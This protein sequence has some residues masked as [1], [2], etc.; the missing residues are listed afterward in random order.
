MANENILKPDWNGEVIL[1]ITSGGTDI[2]CLAYL[3]SIEV[4]E[5]FN[6]IA[7]ATISFF[8]DGADD[9][10][11]TDADTFEPGKEIEIFVGYGEAEERLFS[12]V[13]VRQKVKISKGFPKLIV[14]SKHAAFRMTLSRHTMR[15][16]DQ[17]DSEVVGD[18]IAKYGIPAELED[19]SIRHESA[20]QFNAT[21]WDYIN[22]RTEANGLLLLTTPEGISV[23]KPDTSAEPVI[24]IDQGFSMIDMEAELDGM[25]VADTYKAYAFNFT[26]QEIEEVEAQTGGCDS[27]QGDIDSADLSAKVK[28]GDRCIDVDGMVANTDSITELAASQMM[29]SSMARLSGTVTFPGAIAIHPGNVIKLENVAK[30]VGG[31]AYVTS[32]LNQ[33]KD[34]QWKT[35]VRFGLDGIRYFDRFDD[36]NAAPASGAFPAVNGLQVAKVE[37]LQDDPLGENRIL[38]KV[39]HGEDTTVWAR[40]ALLD[41]GNDRGSFF[42]PEIGDEVIVGFINDNPNLAV[43]LGMLHSSSSPSPIEVTDDNDIKG[44]FTREKIRLE[45]DDYKKSITLQT[46]GGNKVVISDDAKGIAME[47]QNG[48]KITMDSNGIKIESAK[49]LELKASQD[50]K[51]SGA[52]VTAE[53]NAS[54]KATGNSGA[55]VSTSAIA[56]LK[57]SIV[58]IH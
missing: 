42:I 41:A 22:M 19:T 36:I 16:E 5:E 33:V 18:I 47:D 23:I 3:E 53:A 9:F 2:G 7:T 46:P 37:Q 35:C 4:S 34:G 55:E 27:S 10:T 58:Q 31:N 6:R 21:D 43:V 32:V 20:V 15:Y 45:F 51:I 38:V 8:E 49:A 14:T 26:T 56:V 28:C 52:N 40:V 30:R 13:I 12:G 44:F 11:L 24:Q 50:V 48:N 1:R 25:S 54:F 39:L 17:S 57:G 29:R